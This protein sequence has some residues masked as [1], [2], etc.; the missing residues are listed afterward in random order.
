MVRIAQ[1]TSLERQ[2]RR[3][4]GQHT[5]RP[6]IDRSRVQE[7]V[8]LNHQGGVARHHREH[9]RGRLRLVLDERQVRLRTRQESVELIESAVGRGVGDVALDDQHLLVRDRIRGQRELVRGTH[10][11]SDQELA[12]HRNTLGPQRT[13]P[14]D[15]NQPPP[16]HPG[17]ADVGGL[18]SMIRIDEEPAVGT[19]R[20]VQH[21]TAGVHH[22]R[23]TRL[24][25]S[26]RT[27]NF[28]TDR[29]AGPHD[30][31]TQDGAR[32]P[33][34]RKLGASVA[35]ATPRRGLFGVGR[36]RGCS[37]IHGGPRSWET[38]CFARSNV[39]WD[40]RSGSN[41]EWASAR[42][43]PTPGPAPH[44]RMAMRTWTGTEDTPGARG[45]AFEFAGHARERCFTVTRAFVDRES[46][47]THGVRLVRHRRSIAGGE[48]S[49]PDGRWLRSWDR[50]SVWISNPMPFVTR[51]LAVVDEG[52]RATCPPRSSSG[53]RCARAVVNDRCGPGQVRTSIT[54]AAAFVPAK[55]AQ[56][57][58]G[59][60][61]AKG[62]NRPS[63]Q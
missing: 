53:V 43:V 30:E 47:R 19:G 25:A 62:R 63:A 13:A 23:R 8:E 33:A 17:H 52:L 22:E 9:A 38:R 34:W 56:V 49:T 5:D 55:L 28:R 10:R 21:R 12:V 16:R 36:G 58:A 60:P 7:V 29:Q 20:I 2:V 14:E 27:Q 51:T 1:N 4:P 59:R 11:R 35:R 48:R 24:S 40:C 57:G 6:S 3:S 39:T 54:D 41:A 31:T 15:L 18:T 32:P 46:R 61:R 50:P 26:T 42:G 37:S 44:H 45:L